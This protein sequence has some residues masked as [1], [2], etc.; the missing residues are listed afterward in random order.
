[1]RL[2]VQD[3]Q[4]LN[5]LDQ[6]TFLF[7]ENETRHKENVELVNRVELLEADLNFAAETLSVVAETLSV[8]AEN[9]VRTQDQVDAL[10]TNVRKNREATEYGDVNKDYRL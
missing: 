1:M 3:F 6:A 9:A 10:E 7:H 8:V 4:K 2:N 5:I